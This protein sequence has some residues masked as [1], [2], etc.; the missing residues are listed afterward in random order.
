[1][2]TKKKK[3]YEEVLE[4]IQKGIG[5][6][7][8]E[9]LN[10]LVLEKVQNKEE[11]NQVLTRPDTQFKTSKE[12]KKELKKSD[13]EKALAMLDFRQG[14]ISGTNNLRSALEKNE[15]LTKEYN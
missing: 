7:V 1:M 2:A 8:R 13:K 6:R 5:E 4:R 14:G 12:A 10:S 9:N 15:K 3:E 11:S